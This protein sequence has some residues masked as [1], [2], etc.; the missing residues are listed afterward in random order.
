MKRALLT[1]G[2]AFTLALGAWAQTP[3]YKID[4]HIKGLKDTTV[5]LGYYYGETT[6]VKD[7]ARV[8]HNGDFIFDGKEALP[9]GVYMVVLGQSWIF[10]FVVS[11]KQRFS[12]TTDR[13]DYVKN[14]VVKGDEDN[15]L[16]FD[17]LR[18]NQVKREESEPYIKII[19]DS[20]K[21][22]EEKKPAREAYAKISDNVMA[23]QDGL[24]AK[25]PK[26]LTARL[27][28]ITK[29]IQV[30]DPP[31]RADGTVDS[32][33]QLR[34]YR[35]HFFDYF[36]LADDAL[37]RLPKP[38]YQEKVY[39]YLDKL[40][41]QTPDSIMSAINGLALKAKKNQET[42]KYVVWICVYKYQRPTIMGLDEVYVRLY[43]KYYASGDMDFW[44]NAT[45]K[46]NLKEYA[47]KLRPSLIGKTGANLVMQD[48]HLKP[49]S[50]YDLKT[51]YTI[52][53]IFDPDCG[54]CR[55]ESP[56]LVSFYN[57]NKAKFNLEVYAVSADT[58]MQKM[59]DY[60]KEMK[61]TWVTVNGPRS[62]V[63]PYSKLYYAETT[64]SLYVLDDKRKII[65]K[66]IPAE[67]LEEFFMNYEKFL[68]RKT[69]PKSKG[70]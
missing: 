34:Y 60:V 61:M 15:Q 52:L 70:D 67:K 3:G 46:K 49:R 39:E 56:K 6:Y 41:F 7:T 45:L 69:V 1:F 19:K 66:G 62:Y 48:E 26:S 47:D 32:T 31:K 8:N 51:R 53:Y 43:D 12:L 38:F 59:K 5:Y 10:Q 55:E 4:M 57:K 54:H 24:I 40:F 25:S 18:Y 27:I 23:Y 64:P 33:F 50:M 44:I 2:F 11:E 17:N 30:P 36:D 16:F 29:P 9:Q 20:T 58:S 68:V 42:Y 63:G 37:I 22:E 28:Q 21:T 65:A 13:A 14:M 35:E